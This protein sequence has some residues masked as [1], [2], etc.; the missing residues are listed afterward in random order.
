[1]TTSPDRTELTLRRQRAD[2]GGRG[3]SVVGCPRPHRGRGYCGRHYGRLRRHGDPLGGGPARARSAV[4]YAAAHRRVRAQRGPAAGRACAACTGPATLW[5]YDGTDPD[6]QTETGRG[7]RYSTDPARYRPLCRSCHRRATVRGAEAGGL[8][9]ERAVRL[10]RGGASAR[11]I[12]VLLDVS[13]GT[14]LAALRA[15]GVAIRPRGRAPSTG[16]PAVPERRPCEQPSDE[17]P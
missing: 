1:M 2:R 16:R 14:V 3:C 7:R 4:G 15:H 6:E 5:S 10:Y 8:D 11:G 9:L 17:A 12:A 13:P